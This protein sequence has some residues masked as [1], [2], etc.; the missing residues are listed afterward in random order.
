MNDEIPDGDATLLRKYCALPA[1]EALPEKLQN[2]YWA[3]KIVCDRA[4]LQVRGEFVR[5]AIECGF[6][7]LTEREANPDVLTLWRRG[8]VK[9]NQPVLVNWREKK[10]PGT[11]IFIN[12][13]NE[14]TV[15]I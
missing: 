12:A 11:L 4:G 5:I 8:V 2:R 10:V 1:S 6:G 15:M 3:N 7:K 14:A 13:T 9:C